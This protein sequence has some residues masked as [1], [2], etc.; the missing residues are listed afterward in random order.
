M[1]VLKPR[2]IEPFLAKPD[3]SYPVLMLYGPDAGLVSERADDLAKKTGIDLKDPFNLI[4]LSADDAASDTTKIADEAHT[5]AMFGGKRLIRISGHTRRDLVRSLKPVLEVPP[6]DAI[7]IVEAGDLTKSSSLRQNL[8]K[9]KKALCIPCYQD[10]TAALEKL[11]DD[12]IVTNGISI[13]RETR[14]EL[15]S[16]LGNNRMLSRNE[17]Q[18]LALYCGDRK[19]LTIDDIRAVVGDGSNLVLNELIDSVATGNSGLLQ[20]LLPKV[21]EAGNA[22]D[23]ILLATLKHFQQLQRMRYQMESK[24]QG[25]ASFVAGVRPRIHFLRKD[26]ITRAL[27]TW[28]VSNLAKALARLDKTML[29]CRQ[30]ASAA[31]SIASTTLLALSLEARS[32]KRR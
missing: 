24:R 27:S 21:V 4:Q 12:E 15:R 11:I 14:T 9:H 29:Y 32:L 30:N 6:E 28:P 25:A 20:E 3:F 2:E 7:I 5:I 10:N 13:D 18:K 16:L 17:L 22:P 19:S 23:I 8:E 1:A 26:Q 31:A